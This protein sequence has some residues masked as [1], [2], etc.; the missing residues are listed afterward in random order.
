M[1]PQMPATVAIADPYDAGTML[2]SVFRRLGASSI[3]VAST[4]SIP[5]AESTV[6][7]PRDFRRLFFW[8]DDFAGTVAALRAEGVTHV[9]AGSERGVILADR[10]AESLNLPG[11]G[12]RLSQARRDKF[13]MI[14]QAAGHGVRT[15]K[16]TQSGDLEEI[17]NWIE[18][19]DYWPVVLKPRSA[20]GSESVRFCVSRAA[21]AKAFH[22]IRGRT[23][24]L[25][26]QNDTVLAQEY[27]CGPEYV[28]DTVSHDGHHRLAGL[29]AYGKSVATYDNVG[30]MATKRLL[31]A[32]GPLADILFGF[33]VRV[34]DALGIRHG[35][36]HCEVIVDE[37]GPVLVE[38]GA[39][40]HGGP[41]AHLMSRAATGSSQCDLLAQSC[42]APATFLAET[43]Q[44]YVMKGAAAMAL[45]RDFA[46]KGEIE[47][48]PS[49]RSVTWNE[50]TCAAPTVA[51]IA[52]LI[53]SDRKLI[54]EDLEVLTG[55]L[56][57]TV[58][59]DRADVLS[60]AP[61]WSDLLERSS[62][63]RAF[64]G[65]SW[66]LAALDVQPD[67][68]PRV[69]VTY[70][71]GVLVGVLAL[72]WDREKG[73]TRFASDLSDFNDAV[74]A[75]NDLAAARRLMA[76][77]R[78]RFPALDLRCVR[79]DAACAL[80]ARPTIVPIDPK[81]PC[82]FADS[83]T[84]YETWLTSRAGSFRS[85]LGRVERR[86]AAHGLRV[87]R[88]DPAR[89]GGLEL[90]ALFL[91]LQRQRFGDGSL[92]AR[93]PVAAAFVERALPAAFQDRAALVFG[94]WSR[95]NLVGL[96]ICMVGS[97]SLGYWNAG[98]H[99]DYAGF[100]PGT[101]MV[102][103]ALREACDRGLAEFDFLRGREAYKMKW[104]TGIR[105][106][107]RLP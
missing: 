42:L 66:Y 99:A 105:E 43:K 46:L 63:N 11:N 56:P 25:G 31:P 27:I 7:D 96:N 97:D 73:V 76:A 52:T 78:A 10:L 49:A 75:L 70:R 103:A 81:I 83:A 74:V 100:S 64:G 44:R 62:C 79:S 59:T 61:A 54:E 104:C 80:S 37:Y 106:I 41:P 94:L 3:M 95:D 77:A 85:D 58:L 91:M 47:G 24:S 101:L 19:G 84:G 86:A 32:A 30:L 51:G 69:L 21:V 29:W 6:F 38:I 12:T 92:F 14:E 20:K 55:G 68:E 89:H 90:P 8:N 26:E 107:G 1:R 48:L 28:V 53:H 71:D 82:P 33:A 60:I 87:E 34:L 35:A 45:L 2:A 65:P 93:N 102:H 15:P 40:L 18:A 23:N 39:R 5:A 72:V 22:A 17:V 88:L 36:G 50:Q 67:V 16:Q 4:H 98:F 57:C 13:V 9:V